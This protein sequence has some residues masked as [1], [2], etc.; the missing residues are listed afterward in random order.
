M[1]RRAN[2][3]R[4]RSSAAAAPMSRNT[5]GGAAD[6]A[7]QFSRMRMSQQRGGADGAAVQQ[8]NARRVARTRAQHAPGRTRLR[9]E[10][11]SRARN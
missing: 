7:A 10:P 5:D 8:P 9:P 6:A 3:A 2:F 4:T 1:H 11:L